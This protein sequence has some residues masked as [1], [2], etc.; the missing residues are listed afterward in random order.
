VSFH[1]ILVPNKG[2]TLSAQHSCPI[3]SLEHRRHLAANVSLFDGTLRIVG[4]AGAQQ[5]LVYNYR[6]STAPAQSR[7]IFDVNGLAPSTVLQFDEASRRFTESPERGRLMPFITLSLDGRLTHYPKEQIQRIE[8]DLGGGDDFFRSTLSVEHRITTGEGD[9]IVHTVDG[10]D[11]IDLGPGNDYARAQGNRD[12][13]FGGEGNDTLFGGDGTDRLL[14]NDGD[15]VLLD[16][17]G[18]DSIAGGTGKDRF[19]GFGRATPP[20]VLRSAS[21]VDRQLDLDLEMRVNPPFSSGISPILLAG[22]DEVAWKRVKGQWHVT[23]TETN[24]ASNYWQ[25]YD[26]DPATATLTAATITVSDAGYTALWTQSTTLNLGPLDGVAT[27]P[28]VDFLGN[29]VTRLSVPRLR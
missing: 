14:G 5:V 6:H 20:L 26:F 18:R 15:D 16:Y 9:D 22:A 29:L 17:D 19:V 13:V 27:V 4:D 11:R 7:L 24:G 10:R 25:A 8:A 12:T 21:P 28:V 1:G 3:E 2:S 23:I